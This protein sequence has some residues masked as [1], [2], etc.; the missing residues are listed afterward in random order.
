MLRH[1]RASAKFCLKF[2]AVL[3]LLVLVCFVVHEC[4]LEQ[5]KGG[6]TDLSIARSVRG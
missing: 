6:S 2:F 3:L 1:F 4:T 5:S